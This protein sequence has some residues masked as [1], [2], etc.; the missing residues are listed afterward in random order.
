MPLIIDPTGDRIGF[1]DEGLAASVTMVKLFHLR[2]RYSYSGIDA[3][4]T[5]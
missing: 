2:V 1:L 3:T 4:S 5:F